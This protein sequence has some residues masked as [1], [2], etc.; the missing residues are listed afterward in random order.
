MKLENQVTIKE[1]SQRLKELGVKQESLY[2][3]EY[4]T[5]SKKSSIID[6]GGIRGCPRC[7][8]VVGGLR[9]TLTRESYSSFTVAELGEILRKE[10]W[11][12]PEYDREERAWIWYEYLPSSRKKH[13]IHDTPDDTDTEAEARAKM[14]IYLLEN[15][16][17]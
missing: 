13:F 2:N 17:L 15:K 16:L 6:S 10:E 1:T 5:F 4:D 14:L 3:W 9:P 11:E 7:G 8:T 12:C